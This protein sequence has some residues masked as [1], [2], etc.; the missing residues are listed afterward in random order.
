MPRSPHIPGDI[1]RWGSHLAM[2]KAL[3]AAGVP[4]KELAKVIPHAKYLSVDGMLTGEDLAEAFVHAYPKGAPERWFLD[5]PVH[6]DGR[7][8]VVTK[9][10]GTDTE[11]VLQRLAALAP[12]GSGVGYESVP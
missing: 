7:T 9:M 3:H 10:W 4:A 5:S 11:P 12:P 1:Y 8:W 6:D 2:I